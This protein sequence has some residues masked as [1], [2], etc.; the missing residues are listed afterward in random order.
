[1][2]FDLFIS[3]DELDLSEPF[4]GQL[5]LDA[6]FGAEHLLQTACPGARVEVTPLGVLHGDTYVLYR[7]PIAGRADLGSTELTLDGVLLSYPM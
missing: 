3:E 1:M 4:G 7:H 2:I 6:V 5:A